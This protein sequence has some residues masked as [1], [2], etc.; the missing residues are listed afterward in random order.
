MEI[1]TTSEF[2]LIYP[3]FVLHK[4][5]EMPDGFNDRLH[6]LAAEDA[7]ANRIR[8][9]GDGRNVGDQTNHLGH[10]RH[11]FLMDRQDPAIAALAQMVAAGVREY[12]QLAYGY[13]HSGDIR[14]MSDT[15][16]QRRALRENVGINSRRSGPARKWRRRRRRPCTC[17]RPTLGVPKGRQRVVGHDRG[18][19]IQ[20]AAVKNISDQSANAFTASKTPQKESQTLPLAQFHSPL[21]G[22]SWVRDQLPPPLAPVKAFSRSGCGRIFLLFSRVM[23]EGLSTGPCARRPGSGLSGPIFSGPDDCADLVKFYQHA[24]I[25]VRKSNSRP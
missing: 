16:W 4:H 2:Q 1:A 3:S 6:A 14:M 13:D 11:N 18:G 10:L 21:R 23:R 19:G 9:T 7:E 12:L 8:E 22:E 25:Y 24:D 20:I 17:D 5:W 15:F